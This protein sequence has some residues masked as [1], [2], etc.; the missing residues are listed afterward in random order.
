MRTAFSLNAI[1]FRRAVEAV[2]PAVER[3]NAIPILSAMKITANDGALALTTTNMDFE[4]TRRVAA[5]VVDF[6]AACVSAAPLARLLSV[7]APDDI[8]RVDAMSEH[9]GKAELDAPEASATLPTWEPSDF[10]DC[11]IGDTL[12]TFSIPAGVL[13]R[14]IVRTMFAISKCETRYYLNGVNVRRRDGDLVFEAT[15]GHRLAQA[16]TPA[17]EG[18][19]FPPCIIPRMVVNW[20]APVLAR[21][22]PDA[23]VSVGVSGMGQA[24][25]GVTLT[26]PDGTVARAKV[27]DGTFPDTERVIP[28]AK[29]PVA[30]IDRRRLIRALDIVSSVTGGWKSRT[31]IAF[32]FDGTR[33]TL[34]ARS[35]D[36]GTAK[37]FVP[38]AYTGPEVRIGF[39]QSYIRDLARSCAGDTIEM[40]PVSPADPVLVNDPSDG[41][42]RFVL[43]PMRL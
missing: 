37:A 14:L 3:R 10:P 40:I 31:P 17:P 36:E 43:M 30:Q 25:R 27:I 23:S 13:H 16:F 42:V 1:E 28:A 20:L 38:M 39:N 41:S 26:L 19:S 9:G 35:P 4:L 2:M 5:D 24:V 8:V 22:Q 15:D 18:A 21:A 34:T 7:M 11:P 6:G 29:E 32:N 33:L 12:A